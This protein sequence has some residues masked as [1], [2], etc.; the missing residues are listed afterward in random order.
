[1]K[2]TSA[3]SQEHLALW[4]QVVRNVARAGRLSH[5]DAQDFAQSMHVRLLERGYDIFWRFAG[6]SSM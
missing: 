5:E 4:S 6:R 1:M 3:P 2:D